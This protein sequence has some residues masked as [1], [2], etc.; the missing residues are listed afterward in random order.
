MEWLTANPV[1][2][3]VI[4]GIFCIVAIGLGVQ[5]ARLSKRYRRLESLWEE[6]SQGVEGGNLELMLRQQLAM[7]T[8]LQNDIEGIEKRLKVAEAKL[9]QSKRYVG[10]VRYDAFNDVGGG[11]S[12]SLAVCDENGDGAIVTSQ[13]GRMDCRV[14]GKSLR[15]G[16]SDVSLTAEEEQ[17]LEEAVAGRSRP[18]IGL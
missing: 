11:Q 7:G 4:G 9:V 1:V 13:V 8:Q 10:L 16:R 15:A 3:P 14:F 18:K 17:A 6:L 12:F 2:V 5:N